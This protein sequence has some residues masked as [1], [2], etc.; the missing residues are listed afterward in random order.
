MDHLYLNELKEKLNGKKPTMQIIT[1]DDM[2]G[3]GAAA[4]VFHAF[5]DA[6]IVTKVLINLQIL[7]S[8]LTILLVMKA[9]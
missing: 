3:Y 8:L 2:D 5:Y 4:V 9:L 6:K 7:F 1:H